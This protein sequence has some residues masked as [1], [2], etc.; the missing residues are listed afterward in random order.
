MSSIIKEQ[1]T[2]SEQTFLNRYRFDSVV[3]NSLRSKLSQGQFSP[4]ANEL[5]GT[6]GV[7]S[8]DSFLS[9]P[10]VGSEAEKVGQEALDSGLVAAVILNG[11]MATRFGGVVKG[12]VEVL[13]GRSFL[14][15]KLGT[16]SRASSRAPVFLMNSFATSSDTESHL[17]S[18]SF[19]NPIHYVTQG[20]SLRLNPDGSLF[21]SSGGGL[22]FYA[23]GHG[24]VFDALSSSPS[25]QS[26]VSGGGL[27]VHV[28]NVDN[29]AATLSPRV[30][31][32]HILAGRRVSVEVAPRISGDKGGAPVLVDG[33]LEIVEGFRFPSSFDHESL[34]VFNTNNLVM[35]TNIFSE[36]PPLRWYR[37]D[38]TVDGR[39]V[40]Q[41]ER[42][43]GEITAFEDSSYLCVERSGPDGRFLPVKTPSD[44]LSLR[45]EIETRFG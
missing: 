34:S 5:S 45:N 33:H 15:L 20:I 42:L 27:Y 36:S 32:S 21:R 7:P 23:P 3:F 9:W 11:G 25:F 18:C 22:S 2:S 26:F 19:V 16:I 13:P 38:K 31:G 1:L 17:S 44:L 8:P 35:D 40:V 43:M 6:L 10:S 14:D 39:P 29:L 37:A 41:F 24:D 12:V 4:S 28:S 30:I